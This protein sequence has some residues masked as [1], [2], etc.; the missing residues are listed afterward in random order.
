VVQSIR[1][2]SIESTLEFLETAKVKLQILKK[3][4]DRKE[5]GQSTMGLEKELLDI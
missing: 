5:K 2:A 4:K 1:N 3:M